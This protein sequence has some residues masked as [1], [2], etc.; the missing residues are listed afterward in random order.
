[1]PEDTQFPVALFT[2]RQGL[3]GAVDADEL[4]VLRDDLLCIERKEDK[5]LDVIQQ[6]IQ[7]A[8]SGSG[9]FQAETLGLDLLTFHAFPLIVRPKP[10]KK[11]V[12]TG[13]Q[14]TDFCLDS[15]G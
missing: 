11:E 8:Q 4:M 3:Q 5:I 10:R 15:V 13:G 1:M 6:T 7:A 9:A 12:P 14:R 2:V